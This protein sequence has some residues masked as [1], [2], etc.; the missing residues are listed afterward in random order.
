MNTK[1]VYIVRHGESDANATGIRQGADAILTERGKMQAELV[2]KRLRGNRIERIIASPYTRAR[3][4]AAII[5]RELEMEISEHSPLFIE[6]VNPSIML[7]THLK[8]PVM[9][10]I[11]DEIASNYDVSGWRHSDE[12]NFEDL[13]SRAVN[14]LSFLESLPEE[15]IL[16]TSHGLFMK[17]ILAHV[18]L[19]SHLNGRI[20]WDQFI[21][22][23]NVE[24]TGILSLQYTDNYFGTK[25]YWKLISWN[26]HAHL[27]RH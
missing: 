23:K 21:P 4:T 16:V 5:A 27:E 8:D 17:V 26:D 19:G 15:R 18:L 6:R 11:W 22:T 14:A 3:E 2:G 12:E 10:R 7:G 1:H 9:E 24:N 13:R 20:F 25:K